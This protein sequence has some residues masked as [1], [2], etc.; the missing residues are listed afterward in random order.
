MEAIILL[1]EDDMKC[2]ICVLFCNNGFYAQL[3]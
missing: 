3:N 1:V 2:L